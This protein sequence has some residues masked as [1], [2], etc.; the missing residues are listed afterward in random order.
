MNA[1]TA[2]TTTQAPSVNL[3]NR[4]IA[5]ATAVTT[6]PAP[7]IAARWRQ[8][9]GRFRRQYTTS[10]DR[11]SVN[12]VNTPIANRG[13]SAWVL[14]PTATSSAPDK[15]ASV[16]MPGAN[17][18]RSSRSENRCGRKWSRASRLASTGSPPKE[19]LAASARTAVI[20]SDIATYAQFLPTA[21]AMIWLS[22]VWPDRGPMCQ[23]SA[24]T[25]RPTSIAPRITP[26][27]NS[28]RL[29]RT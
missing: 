28:V 1:G 27:S 14:P 21:A 29:A 4:N 9:G 6:A 3:L 11:D 10:P 26:S 22:T 7:L 5:V 23:R 18:C 17:T 19:V 8:R 24:S 2:S 20:V 13:I 15:T 12:P 25:A 16:T